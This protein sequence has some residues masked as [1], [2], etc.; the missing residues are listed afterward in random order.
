MASQSQHRVYIPS[1]ARANQYILAQFRP[2]DAFYAHFDTLANAYKRLQTQLFALCEE[3]QLH[4][5]HFIANDKLPIVRF[6]DEPY[7]LETDKQILFFYH[8]SYHESHTG[9]C[10]TDYKATKISFLFLATGDELRAQ[11]ADFHRRVQKVLSALQEY[12]PYQDTV[13]KIRDHQHLT[14]DLFSRLKRHKESYGYKLRT[15][16]PRYEARNCT[17]PHD[18]R[19]LTYARFTLPL[20]RQVKT[21]LLNLNAT[22]YQNL[23]QHIS[24]LFV[25]GCESKHM[26]RHAMVATGRTPIVRHRHLDTT[27]SDTELEK[28]SF[29]PTNTQTQQYL[30]WDANKLAQSIDFI[31]VAG[32]EDQERIGYGKFM[33]NVESIARSLCNALQIDGETQRINTRFYQHISYSG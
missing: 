9:F 6:H 27:S 16:A 11:A 28:L 10:D 2:D 18:H 14:Y 21:Q 32:E 8:P 13:F 24:D 23:Y 20:T 29:E 17:I 31:I 33:N 12:A 26:Q 1:N 15:I 5:V 4:N 3:Y 7:C 19:A 22:D 30:V 25:Q